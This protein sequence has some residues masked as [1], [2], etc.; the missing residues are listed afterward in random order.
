M[1]QHVC[2]REVR[3]VLPVKD[4]MSLNQSMCRRCL[5]KSQRSQFH[6]H[7]HHLALSK[8]EKV[9]EWKILLSCIADRPS[10]QTT[11]GRLSWQITQLTGAFRHPGTAPHQLASPQRVQPAGGH[12]IRT[13]RYGQ[14][15][16]SFSFP[17]GSLIENSNRCCL[18]LLIYRR[19]FIYNGPVHMRECCFCRHLILVLLCRNHIFNI[20]WSFHG[21]L[22][23]LKLLFLKLILSSWFYETNVRITKD[24]VQIGH[25]TLI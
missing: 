12:L 23:I 8:S 10:Q 21:I 24:A 22:Y 13:D 9:L 20:P 11:G 14:L 2:Y 16:L 19:E 5:E 7:Q 1:R 17:L 25:N 6:L 18:P 4:N 15:C 3:R